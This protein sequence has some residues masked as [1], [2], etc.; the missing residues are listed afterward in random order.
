MLFS[1]FTHH[2]HFYGQWVGKW[3]CSHIIRGK[4]KGRNWREG[5]GKKKPEKE[6][7]GNLDEQ[8]LYCSKCRLIKNILCLF[9]TNDFIFILIYIICGMRLRSKLGYTTS[10]IAVE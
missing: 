4:E 7:F 6:A 8:I 3:K 2:H 5:K 9:V 1:S 10:C